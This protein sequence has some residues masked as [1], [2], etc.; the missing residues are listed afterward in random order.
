MI[1][2]LNLV[3]VLL[4]LAIFG[5][6]HPGLA[7]SWS[8]DSANLPEQLEKG[9]WQTVSPGVLQRSVEGGKVETLGFGT[10]GLRF[11]IETMRAD[12]A[13]LRQEYA[14]HPS[15]ALRRTIRAHRAEI[16]RSEA[17]LRKTEAS[18][19]LE[20]S[21]EAIL[22]Q[23]TDCPVNYDGSAY[24]FPLAQG[25]GA[26][27]KASFNNDC[28]YTGEVY[29]HAYAE[30]IDA[31]GAFVSASMSDPSPNSYRTG[32][33]V[34]AAASAGVSGVNNC[35]SYSYASV[36]SYDL[37]ITYAQSFTNNECSGHPEIIPFAA[38][39]PSNVAL[40]GSPAL[41]PN[42]AAMVANLNSSQHKAQLY[43]FGKTIY[44]ASAGTPRTIVC[45]KTWGTCSLSQSLVPIHPSWKPTSGSEGAM[46]VIDYTN[47]K[48]Y[49]FYQV[50]T[51]PDGTVMINADGTVS[52][53][54]GEVTDLDGSGLSR[55]VS[56]SNLSYL[57]GTVRLFEMERA[58]TDPVNAIQH[59][60]AFSSS[61]AC[62]TW[63]YPATKSN[64]TSTDPG[65]IPVG[66][67]IF[68]DSFADCST[69]SPAGEKAVC[70]ALQK[71]GA[72]LVGFGGSIFSLK[73]E[74]PTDGHPGGSGPDPYP[75]VGFARDYYDMSNIPWSELKVAADCQ[76][77]PY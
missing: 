39:A 26:N 27:A 13:F 77:T 11:R 23:A 56:G 69:V 32:G 54:W 74:A 68:L 15:R 66:S 67:R 22:V 25:A 75:G 60:L 48:I 1:G 72:Y 52:V 73:F 14:R 70:Y 53:G 19:G 55:A 35:H 17:A 24:S 71:F 58:A 5:N 12:L 30:A 3:F 63:R 45:T 64:G 51:N 33:K 50:A 7:G 29:A 20:S 44:N 65:C 42:S 46:V 37:E 49:D 2:K 57:V 34:S 21:H 76:C 9:G 43:S 62:T 41:D 47:R 61:Y 38:D 4:G 10:E 18:G 31:N 28:W 16:L 36:T 6:S 40:P 8:P 59:A